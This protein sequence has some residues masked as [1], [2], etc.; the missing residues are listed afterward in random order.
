MA[1]FNIDNISIRGIV[2]CTP[3]TIEENIN[4]PIFQEGEAEKVIASTGIERRR[5]ADSTTTA[6]DLCYHAAHHLIKQLNWEKESIDCII[7]VSQTPDYKLP[8]TSCIIQG[9][10]GL[11]VHCFAMDISYG[12]PGW[13]YGLSV[14]ASMISAGH[15]KRGL[16]LVGDTPTKFKNRNDKTSWPLFGDAGSATA[17]EFNNT[18]KPMYFNLQTDGSSHQ[19]III[20]DGGARNPITM[21]S[22]QEKQI[23]PGIARR[24]IDS[25]MDGLAVFQ[26]GIKRGPSITQQLLEETY[27]TVDDVDVFVFHQANQYMNEKIRK[28]LHIDSNKVPYSLKDYGNTSCVTIPLTMTVACE[29]YD[30]MNKNNTIVATAFGVGLSWGSVLIHQAPLKCLAHIDY[31]G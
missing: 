25:N 12:C 17:I 14:I 15:L 9:K 7:F 6:G 26:F 21:E 22:L 23:E 16:L 28:K 4:Y 31:E 30:L 11:P 13:V 24:A 10:L 2:S 29:N 19:A 3:K 18:A 1:G 20:T 8:A 27:N 5:V